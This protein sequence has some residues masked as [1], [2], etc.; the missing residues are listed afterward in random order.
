MPDFSL[1]N[2]AFF[3]VDVP[4]TDGAGASQYLFAIFAI[5]ILSLPAGFAPASIP[6]SMDCSALSYG[7]VC[8][9]QLTDEQAVSVSLRVRR[10][11]FLLYPCQYLGFAIFICLNHHAYE[12]I[13]REI[14][15]PEYL[16]WFHSE[17]LTYFLHA[18]A[19]VHEFF[20]YCLHRFE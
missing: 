5:E 18:L 17:L 19:T 2:Y 1:T 6:F 7:C 20:Y 13:L 14:R 12:F 15:Q 3:G 11:S 10:H 8:V 16:L 4:A 9:I